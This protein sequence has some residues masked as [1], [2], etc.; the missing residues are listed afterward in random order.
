MSSST[1]SGS[2]CL[3]AHVETNL[4]F[5]KGMCAWLESTC[6]TFCFALAFASL[7]L[8]TLERNTIVTTGGLVDYRRNCMDVRK[9]D[10]SMDRGVEGCWQA[11]RERQ[12]VYSGSQEPMVSLH[13]RRERKERGK[14]RGGGERQEDVLAM[15]DSWHHGVHTPNARVH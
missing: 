15:V 4:G 12:S 8:K 6:C 3:L 11:D 1:S 9:T 7:L 13:K 14:E 10:K 2:I 5:A